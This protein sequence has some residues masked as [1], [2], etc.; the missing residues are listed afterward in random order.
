MGYVATKGGTEAVLKAEQLVEYFRL[1]GETEP[2]KIEQIKSQFRLAVDRAMSEGSLYAP[3]LAA[4]ALKQSEGDAVEASFLLRAYRSTLPRLSYSL[5]ANGT[6]M[7]L[8]RRIS[9]T[10]KDI[11]GGQL[12]GPTRD[13]QPRLLNTL[14]TSESSETMRRFLANFEKQVESNET[15]GQSST[16]PKVIDSMRE[17]DLLAE[18]A[19]IGDDD[20]D[21]PFDVTRKATSFPAPRSA[22]LQIMARGDAGSLLALA[23]SSIR[24][25]GDVHPTLGEMRVGYLPIEVAHPLTGESVEIG[26]IMITECE[27]VSRVKATGNEEIELSP[28]FGLGYGFSFGHGEDKAVSMSILDRAISAAKSG[29]VHGQS[30]PAADEEFVLQHIDAIEASGFT[31]HYKLPHYV[32]FQADISVLERAKDHATAKN[33][34]Q[35]EKQLRLQQKLAKDAQ[36]NTLLD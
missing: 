10:F 35:A 30:G 3:E 2:I 21:E 1:R 18:A 33:A 15:D 4:L 31:A 16:F 34:A 20:I 24:G 9:S 27:M 23:Y 22:R 13:Y 32:T 14:L 11:P 36:D 28:K 6:R 17:Q 25:Y 29:K 7:R 8:I 12:L 5:P 19:S 26:E